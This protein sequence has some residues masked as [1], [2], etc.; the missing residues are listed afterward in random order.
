MDAINPFV[1]ETPGR[2]GRFAGEVK[3]V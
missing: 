1:R 3:T 2:L